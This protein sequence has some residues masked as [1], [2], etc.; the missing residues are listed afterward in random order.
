MKFEIG[1]LISAGHPSADGYFDAGVICDV[2]KS[3]YYI[4][5]QK[6]KE[7]TGPY[8]IQDIEVFTQHYQEWINHVQNN[9]D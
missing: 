8:C 4:L 9:K 2:K 6:D 7:V 5:W 3:K 1:T